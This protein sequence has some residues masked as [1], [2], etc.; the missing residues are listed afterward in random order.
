LLQSAKSRKEDRA[1]QVEREK[2][3]SPKNLA[4]YSEPLNS[5]EK[6]M[7][8]DEIETKPFVFPDG[9]L[10]NKLEVYIAN[11]WEEIAQKHVPEMLEA[12]ESL[13]YVPVYIRKKLASELLFLDRSE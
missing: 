10:D 5:I 9:I 3:F 8:L 7:P 1:K 13:K 4:E 12:L 2:L 11:V 6:L